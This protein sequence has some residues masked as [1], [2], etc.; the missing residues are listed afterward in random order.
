MP[1]V[2]MYEGSWNGGFSMPR[3]F[4]MY[5]RFDD[6]W[7]GT[8]TVFLYA[9]MNTSSSGFGDVGSHDSTTSGR[10]VVAFKEAMDGCVSIL[11]FFLETLGPSFDSSLLESSIVRSAPRFTVFAFFFSSSSGAASSLIT[12]WYLENTSENSPQSGSSS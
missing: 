11:R 9:F 2:S 7:R 4:C 10:R 5:L 8:G 1:V 3:L 6:Q 12:G